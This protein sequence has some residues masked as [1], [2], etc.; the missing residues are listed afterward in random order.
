MAMTGV[1]KHTSIFFVLQ[2]NGGVV[3]QRNECHIASMWLHKL[4]ISS[5]KHYLP[6]NYFA[7]FSLLAFWYLFLFWDTGNNILGI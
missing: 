6:S 2:P 1:A 3:E 7:S 4:V 5:L